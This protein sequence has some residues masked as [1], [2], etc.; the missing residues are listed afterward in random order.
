MVE[1]VKGEPGDP[2][3]VP[4]RRDVHVPGQRDR[5]DRPAAGH[6]LAAPGHGRPGPGQL[7]G[8]RPTSRRAA[9]RAC[10]PRSTAA[11]S[12]TAAGGGFYLNGDYH[13]SLVNGDRVDRVLQERH[14][15][16][17]RVGP[18][19]HDEL[20]DR[21]RAAEPEAARRPRQDRG[22]T[23]NQNVETNFGATLGGGYYVWRSGLGITKDGRIVYV[24]GPALNVQDLADL[25]QRAGAVEGMQMDI[26][27]DW[28][29]FDYYQRQQPPGRP[30]AG[31]RCCRPSSRALTRTTR[32]PPAT[33]RRYTRGD[34]QQD[35]WPRAK[36]RDHRQR[37]PP[38]ALPVT[39]ARWL[40]R[41]HHDDRPRQWPKNLL[42]FAA[43]LAGA[44]LGRDD[45][46]GY[47][48]LA[49]FAFA[50]ASAAVYFVNDVVDA[51]R[52]RRHPVKRNR[53]IAS[54]A[55]PDQHA[56]VL[57]VLAVAARGRRG[58]GDPR[59]AACRGG[60]GV[61][62]PVS[63]CTRSGSST[64]RSSRCCS[65]PPASCCACSAARRRPT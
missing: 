24:Y 56:L 61:P 19:L 60:L 57:A 31:Y 7:G 35:R 55:L 15:Q 32:P 59:A 28:M 58:R 64:S 9:H 16:D 6:V 62:V 36:T 30:D 8:A 50:C 14:G 39:P 11:S 37:C 23:L 27:P 51:E 13:G 65:W 5:V 25:L 52:D 29:K 49:M 40:R 38:A 43:P 1:K 10:S 2:D 21:R 45:G 18:R 54:G 47:A 17:R 26:N 53:P 20:V 46:F 12:W 41:G 4:A 33:S 34:D 42:V 22:R 44:S 48:L 63:S 3:H